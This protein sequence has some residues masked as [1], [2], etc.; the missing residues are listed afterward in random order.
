MNP[1][2]RRAEQI[3]QEA[4]RSEDLARIAQAEKGLREAYEMISD[5]M[6]NGMGY[7]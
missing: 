7:R 4:V 2:I 1:I 6:S 5:S 3:Y